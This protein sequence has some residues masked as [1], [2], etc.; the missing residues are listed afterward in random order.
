[1]PDSDAFEGRMVPGSVALDAPVLRVDGSASWL[2]PQL[3]EGFTLLIYGADLNTE[4]NVEALCQVVRVQAK[5][6]LADSKESQVLMDIDGLIA[7][8]YDMQEGT[9]YLLRPDQHVCARWRQVTT[10]KLQAALDLAL[11]K[12]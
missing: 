12:H 8:R 5:N 10:A 4:E 9:A 2:L 3:S 11:S 6:D 1:T 7:K